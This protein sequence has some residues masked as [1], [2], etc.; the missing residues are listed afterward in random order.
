[1][2]HASRRYALRIGT[3]LALTVVLA[4]GLATLAPGAGAATCGD[5]VLNVNLGSG[6]ASVVDLNVLNQQQPAAHGNACADAAG[7]T[8]VNTNRPA[9]IVRS[10]ELTP[11]PTAPR[12]PAQPRRIE[13][14]PAPV[15]FRI[16]KFDAADGESFYSGDFRLRLPYPAKPPVVSPLAP[17]PRSFA[18]GWSVPAI[19]REVLFSLIGG[20]MLLASAGGVRRMMTTA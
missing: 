19:P 20:L 4:A 14:K 9:P 3:T 11:P 16:N 18:P 5:N 7:C 8:D 13:P 2:P 10:P 6:C 17:A 1:M 12:H 15:V